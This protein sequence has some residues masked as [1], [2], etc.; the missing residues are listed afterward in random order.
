MFGKG[1][2]ATV[3]YKHESGIGFHIWYVGGPTPSDWFGSIQFGNKIFLK[4][5]LFI[6]LPIWLKINTNLVASLLPTRF[7]KLRIMS[8]II[9]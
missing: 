6:I 4:I 7:T 2:F 1:I 3:F 5:L 8:I 9:L